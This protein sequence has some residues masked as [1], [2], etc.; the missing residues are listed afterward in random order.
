[1]D[2][3]KTL[4]KAEQAEKEFGVIGAEA[5]GEATRTGKDAQDSDVT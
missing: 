5:A 1:M 3:L 2:L 4:G